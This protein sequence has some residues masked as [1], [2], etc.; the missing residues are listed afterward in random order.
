MM[1]TSQGAHVLLASDLRMINEKRITV[2]NVA[3]A[4][5][6]IL[7]V[8]IYAQ[9]I[10]GVISPVSLS[11]SSV[12]PAGL[13]ISLELDSRSNI[14]WSAQHA[15]TILVAFSGEILILFN[16]I[17]HLCASMPNAFSD[18]LLALLSLK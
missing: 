6:G 16:K 4:G 1:Q 13:Y 17:L 8:I 14:L 5:S 15:R 12:N 9:T 2:W 11:S 3:V 7:L 18:T 10:P